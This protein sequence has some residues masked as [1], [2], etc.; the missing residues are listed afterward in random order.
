VPTNIYA[1]T[2]RAT[3]PVPTPK[4]SAMIGRDTLTM[5][6]SRAPMNEPS[7]MMK[8]RSMRDREIGMA[9]SNGLQNR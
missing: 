6:L 5:V 8:R 9:T 1:S 4:Y 7:D 2:T 3:S